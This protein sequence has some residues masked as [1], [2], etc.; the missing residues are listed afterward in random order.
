LR[1]VVFSTFSAFY[2]FSPFFSRTAM[3]TMM[4]H[5]TVKA[6]K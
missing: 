5:F 4:L 3:S 2:N 6:L 1:T